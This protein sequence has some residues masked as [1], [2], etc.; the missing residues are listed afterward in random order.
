MIDALKTLEACLRTNY[1]F[2]LGTKYNV[3][4]I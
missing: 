4:T 2:Y 3:Y 1:A